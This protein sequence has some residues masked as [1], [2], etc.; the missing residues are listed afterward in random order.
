[1]MASDLALGRRASSRS[2]ALLG[3]GAASMWVVVA[4]VH[5]TS[6]EGDDNQIWS[7]IHVA[8]LALAPLIAL[9]VI[10]LLRESTG[11]SATVAR[12]SVVIWA[13]TFSAY[14]AMAGV[15]TGFLAQEGVPEAGHL[16]MNMPISGVVGIVAPMAWLI[17][18]AFAT[19]ASKDAGGSRTTS[20]ALLVSALVAFH[21][22]LP[23]ALG[24][25]GLAIAFLT[26]IR[27]GPRDN[28]WRHA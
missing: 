6:F 27:T 26:S 3:V 14:D 16:L 4:L 5:P 21:A 10:G 25:A 17:T 19:L 8:Q 2:L 24:Y 13:V 11:G 7:I 15:S 22:G 12:S 18:A 28:D 9:G 1:M 20:V 23:A